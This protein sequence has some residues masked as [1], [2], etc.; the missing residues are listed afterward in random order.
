MYLEKKRLERMRSAGREPPV[1][2]KSPVQLE[3]P[4]EPKP[5]A[6]RAPCA[7]ERQ[8]AE[9]RVFSALCNMG[10][11][12]QQ[13]MHALAQLRARPAPSEPKQLLRASLALLVQG[14]QTV[15]S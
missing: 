4:V 13:A 5:A 3:P 9:D 11:H 1:E 15:A 7:V 12:K 14:A 6:T 2:L 8:R 10:F